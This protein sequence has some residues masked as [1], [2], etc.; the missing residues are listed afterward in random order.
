MSH[1]HRVEMGRETDGAKASGSGDQLVR[2]QTSR[3][4]AKQRAKPD[5]SKQHDRNSKQGRSGQIGPTR[6]N[7]SPVAPI[8]SSANVQ[9]N[10]TRT[11]STNVQ[12]KVLCMYFYIDEVMERFST[13]SKGHAAN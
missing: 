10:S 8:S 11:F 6:R 7:T 12:E 5:E 1:R 13:S 2:L 3:L 4:G 9:Q